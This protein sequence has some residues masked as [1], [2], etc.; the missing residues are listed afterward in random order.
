V[1]LASRLLEVKDYDAV[2]EIRTIELLKLRFGE[3]A[4]Q[5]CDVM[6]KDMAD[7]KRIDEHVHGDIKS[8]VHPLVIS[9]VF[10][11]NIQGTSLKLTQKLHEAQATYADA[12]HTFKPDKHLRF[13]QHLGT[14]QLSISLDD[15]TIEVEASPLQ[16]SIAELF[17]EKPLWISEDIQERLGVDVAS[18][19]AALGWWAGEGL[20]RQTGATWKLLDRVDD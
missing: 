4:L 6:L 18:V 15:R 19:R 14:V 1:L 7:S 17:E 9:S 13:L 8:V 5:V 2:R 16:A 11:P 12:F 3:G 10:W 20:V